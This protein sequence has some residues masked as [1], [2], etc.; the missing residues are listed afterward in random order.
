MLTY[1]VSDCEVDGSGCV[2]WLDAYIIQNQ[3][4]LVLFHVFMQRHRTDNVV[5]TLSLQEHFRCYIKC[6]TIFIVCFMG[7]CDTI[8]FTMY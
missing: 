5:E 8:L 1:D 3:S 7:Y 6:T 2:V 4:H